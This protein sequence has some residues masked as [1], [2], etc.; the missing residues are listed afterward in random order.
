MAH[1]FGETFYQDMIDRGRRELG[2]VMF[3]GSNIA[4]P[5]Y[6]LRGT[7]GP[8]KQPDSPQVSATE[9]SRDDPAP[10]LSRDDR[11]KDDPDLDM[12]RE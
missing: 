8:P 4:Q 5:M 2:S 6:P 3:D 7:Y 12:D 11:G 10:E 1:K 9:P